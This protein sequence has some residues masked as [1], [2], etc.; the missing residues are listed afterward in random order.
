MDTICTGCGYCTPH[1]DQ[2]IPVADYMQCYNEKLLAGKTDKEMLEVMTFN[3]EWGLLVD[4]EAKANECTQC[5]KC[6][7]ACTQHLN[8]TERL[9]H[10]AKWEKTAGIG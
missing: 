7:E 4:A 2:H 5:G 8:I 1:C 6:Q 9:E 3:H 10:L